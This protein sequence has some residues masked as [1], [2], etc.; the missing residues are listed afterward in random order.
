[1]A[2]LGIVKKMEQLQKSNA[3]LKEKLQDEPVANDA[4]ISDATLALIQSTIEITLQRLKDED[5]LTDGDY[6]VKDLTKVLNISEGCA[7]T[8]T[9][10]RYTAGTTVRYKKSVI[11][12]A[13]SIGGKIETGH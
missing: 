11:D 12:Y 10:G 1:M 6:S 9:T 8:I 5:L 3:L 13:R 7:R 2:Q 4:T